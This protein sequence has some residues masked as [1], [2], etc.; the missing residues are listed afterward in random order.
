[1]MSIEEFRMPTGAQQGAPATTKPEFSR[2][3][4]KGLKVMQDVPSENATRFCFRRKITSACSHTWEARVGVKVS[5]DD[6]QTLSDKEIADRVEIEADR[7][8]A[9][10]NYCPECGKKG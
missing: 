6:L 5:A 2:L 8:F 10:L 3:V 4:S 9:E 7:R 1:M